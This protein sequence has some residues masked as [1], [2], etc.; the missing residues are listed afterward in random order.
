MAAEEFLC[1]LYEF[2]PILHSR[3]RGGNLRAILPGRQ[4]HEVDRFLSASR[5]FVYSLAGIS[6]KDVRP[7][8]QLQYRQSRVGA[9]FLIARLEHFN[10]WRTDPTVYIYELE[11]LIHASRRAEIDTAQSRIGSFGATLSQ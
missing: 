10:C 5:A 2:D 1:C 3:V 9:Q 7:E 4:R 8:I 11:A 6:L